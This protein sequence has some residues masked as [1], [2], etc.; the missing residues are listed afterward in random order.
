MIKDYQWKS[1][2]E[3]TTPNP[4]PQYTLQ[5]PAQNKLIQ[6]REK[7]NKNNN[8]SMPTTQPRTYSDSDLEMESEP[9]FEGP[10]TRAVCRKLT[11][12]NSPRQEMIKKKAKTKST[13]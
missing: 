3:T 12:S 6:L 8:V 2:A 13:K 1:N 7:L 9:T 5:Q 10:H 11:P 4:T